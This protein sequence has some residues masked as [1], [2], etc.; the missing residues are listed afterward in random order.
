MK[1]VKYLNLNASFIPLKKKKSHTMVF[2][3]EVKISCRCS[4]LTS[5]MFSSYQESKNILFT[6]CQ[7]KVDMNKNKTQ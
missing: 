6:Y 2:Q 7:Y 4:N 1:T 3:T 5:T